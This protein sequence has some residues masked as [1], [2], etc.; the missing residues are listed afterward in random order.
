MSHLSNASRPELRKSEVP[1]APSRGNRLLSDTSM[2]QYLLN[3]PC[4]ANIDS[5]I[6]IILAHKILIKD[7]QLNLTN[8]LLL[9]I[10]KT[11]HE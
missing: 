7:C 6:F 3:P 2:C 10:L 1:R 11:L 9:N 5:F 4:R 8:A